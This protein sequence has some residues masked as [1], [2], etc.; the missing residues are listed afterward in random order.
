M[1]VYALRKGDDET[2]QTDEQVLISHDIPSIQA[3]HTASPT[4]LHQ[5]YNSVTKH[6]RLCHPN[7]THPKYIQHTQAHKPRR[8]QPVQQSYTHSTR[9]SIS[10]I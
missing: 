2:L 1:T 6:R 3:R 5:Q 7:P 10:I 4:A 9:P 8:K